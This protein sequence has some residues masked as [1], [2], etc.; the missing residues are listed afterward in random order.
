[1][2]KTIKHVLKSCILFFLGVPVCYSTITKI[3]PYKFIISNE[4]QTIT[5]NV[6]GIPEAIKYLAEVKNISNGHIMYIIT[7]TSGSSYLY[8]TNENI[9]GILSGQSISNGASATAS[10][11]N[12]MVASLIYNSVQLPNGNFHILII[13]TNNSPQVALPGEYELI[14]EQSFPQS[15]SENEQPPLCQDSCPAH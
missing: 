1:M 15:N 3:E 12:N 5:L 10:V 8:H 2:L 6:S 14:Q 13:A 11:D 7:S 4:N 9:E